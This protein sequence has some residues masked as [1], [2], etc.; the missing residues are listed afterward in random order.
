LTDIVDVFNLSILEKDYTIFSDI[1]LDLKNFKKSLDKLEIECF[2]IDDTDV[3]NAFLDIKA[4]SGGLESQ[5]WVSM[6]LKMYIS[7]INKNGYTYDILNITYGESEGI[8]GVSLK[9]IGKYSYGWLKYESG[10]HRLVRKSPFSSNNKRHTTFSS[11]FIYPENTSDLSFIFNNFD[12]KIDT[13]RSSGAGGQHVNKT[14]SAVRVTHIPTNTVVKCQSNRS[15]HKNK[16]QAILQ[17]KAKLNKLKLME[18]QSNKDKI[19]SCKSNITWGNQI[20][21]Y[22]LDK[23]IIRDM[24]TNLEV[25]NVDVV[26]NGDLYPFMYS[27]LSKKIL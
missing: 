15:Q 3:C 2:F 20:R 7:W 1:L 23:S 27:V 11:V 26:L 18:T 6:L 14:E 9:V 22:I 12:L 5:D 21:S 16:S 19:N 13:F 17:L 24:R 10:V 25:N 4:G 8:K